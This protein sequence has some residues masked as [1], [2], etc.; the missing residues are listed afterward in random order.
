VQEETL[1]GEVLKHVS[2]GVD[3]GRLL[4]KTRHHSIHINDVIREAPLSTTTLNVGQGRKNTRNR[5]QYNTVYAE[6]CWV[7]GWEG[8]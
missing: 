4:Y 2:S 7:F 1:R 8:V 5:S 3:P 6:F